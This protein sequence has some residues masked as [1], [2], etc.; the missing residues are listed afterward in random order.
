M[1]LCHRCAWMCS[2]VLMLG[3]FGF[4]GVSVN[5]FA[6]DVVLI[7]TTILPAGQ[8]GIPYSAPVVAGDGAPPFHWYL[9]SGNLPGGLALDAG[10]GAISGT[11]N[12]TGTFSFT[13]GITDAEGFSASANLSVVVTTSADAW[14]SPTYGAAVGSDGLSNTTVGPYQNK[15]SYRFR[16]THT[17]AVQQ[18]MIYIIPD[19]SGYAGGSGGTIQ[20]SINTDDGSDAHNPSGTTLATYYI[21]GAAS[22]PSPQRYFYVMKFVNPPTLNAGQLYHMVFQ[23]IDGEPQ[24]NFISVDALYESSYQSSASAELSDPSAAVLLADSGGP[25]TPRTGFTPIYQL[26]FEDGASQGMGYV[27]AWVGNQQNI[28]GSSP[29]R[30]TFTVT[31]SQISVTSAAIRLSRINGENPL[32]IRFENADGSLIEEGYVPAANIPLSSASSPI[33][34]WA[35]YTFSS[36]HTLVPGQTYH[37]VFE[38][39]ATSTYQAFPL[40]KGNYYGFQSTTF[41]PDGKAQVKINGSWTGWSQW[42]TANRPDDDLQFYMSVAQ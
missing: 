2:I 34:A 29:L 11:P 14:K 3:L 39:S 30:E 10:T 13:A 23:N 16:A 4:D 36:A 26:D 28:S 21:N 33:N 27:E 24:T 5:A 32:T 8:I 6:D 40:Q 7:S 17:G 22:L 41:F 15:V 37:L 9:I 25:W 42:G 35:I 20:V 31:G 18:A 1:R 12:S 38:C 19:K